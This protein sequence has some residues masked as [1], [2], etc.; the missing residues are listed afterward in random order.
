[1]EE[2]PADRRRLV[3]HE[4]T[5]VNIPKILELKRKYKA[6]PSLLTTSTVLDSRRRAELA[7][8]NLRQW[9]RQWIS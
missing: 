8:A 6:R 2:D 1:M 4:G 7:Q 3:Q 9:V 5:M